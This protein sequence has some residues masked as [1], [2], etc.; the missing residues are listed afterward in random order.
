MTTLVTA[1]VTSPAAPAAFFERWADMATWPQWNLDTEWVR[2]DGPFRTGATGTLKPKGGPKVPF[3]VRSMVADREFIDD[4]KLWGATLTFAHHVTAQPDGGSLVEVTV[5]MTGPLARVWT[6]IMGKGVRSSLQRDL[7][8]LAEAT[9]R[10]GVSTPQTSI[11][12]TS[13]PQPS[14]PADD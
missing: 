6:A 4:S 7:D 1:Q 2:L 13:T 14:T 12:Q 3:V 9:E 5:S 10:H 11:P 8:G